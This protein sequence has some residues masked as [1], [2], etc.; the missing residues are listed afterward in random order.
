MYKDVD[1]GKGPF[2]K[3]ALTSGVSESKTI[4]QNINAALDV[5]DSC[6]DIY[7]GTVKS[8]YSGAVNRSYG[9]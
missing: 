4:V 8:G 7:Y 6:K 1:D 3:V 9:T 5:L 2:K